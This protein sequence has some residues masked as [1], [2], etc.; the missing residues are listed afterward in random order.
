MT[1]FALALGVVG[2]FVIPVVGAIL[3]FLPILLWKT[4]LT[5]K[6]GGFVVDQIYE[7]KSA[8]YKFI[9]ELRVLANE[10][11]KNELLQ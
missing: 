4:G 2:F 8:F 6:L 11:E 3:G 7:V 5:P 9:S 1:V 10:M